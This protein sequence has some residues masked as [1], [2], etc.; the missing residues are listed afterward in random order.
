MAYHRLHRPDEAQDAL[1][2]AVALADQRLPKLDEP[3]LGDDPSNCIWAY[4]L[5]KE[6]T[7]LLQ[8]NPQSATA[9]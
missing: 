9:K 6:A 2:G 3:D 8:Q 4:A 5:F 7:A 1:A